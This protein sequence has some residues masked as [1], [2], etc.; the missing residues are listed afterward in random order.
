[1]FRDA[2]VKHTCVCTEDCILIDGAAESWVGEKWNHHKPK[3]GD[4]I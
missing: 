2:F 3:G 4:L 1:M